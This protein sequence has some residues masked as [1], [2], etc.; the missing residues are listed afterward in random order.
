MLVDRLAA[1]LSDAVAVLPT[2][3]DA[4][5]FRDAEHLELMAY[6]DRNLALVVP[7]SLAGAPQISLP[8]GRV[9]DPERR[10][11]APVGVSL[12]G[13]PGDDDLLLSLASGLDV[14]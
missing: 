1:L 14:A 12:L 3:R 4:A 9:E 11:D 5:P 6:R 8:A 2:A 13:L 7:A 10:T